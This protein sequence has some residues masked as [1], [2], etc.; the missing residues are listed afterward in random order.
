VTGV[1][2]AHQFEIMY[3]EMFKNETNELPENIYEALNNLFLDVDS[4]CRD[5]ELREK[6]DLDDKG[7]LSRAKDTLEK[8]SN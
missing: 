1:I 2:N 8:I 4:Y 3:L 5:P 6:G 7:L